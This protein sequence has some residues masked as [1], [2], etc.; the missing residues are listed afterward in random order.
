MPRQPAKAFREADCIAIV[1][2]ALIFVQRRV[3]CTQPRR[4]PEAQAVIGKV[5]GRFPLA[6]DLV[7]KA[8][9]AK[10]LSLLRAA[11]ER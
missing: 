4:K 8:K 3:P 10:K 2:P 6:G 1:V 5:L 7:S 9:I 11:A